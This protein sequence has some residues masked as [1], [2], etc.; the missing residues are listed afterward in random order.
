MVNII[1]FKTLLGIMIIMLLNHLLRAS[2]NEWYIN[3]F[4]E[5]KNKNKIK[6]K[7]Q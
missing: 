2:S 3:K 5:Y 6:I 4:N 7:K 1:H